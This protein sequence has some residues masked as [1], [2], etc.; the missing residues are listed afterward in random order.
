MRTYVRNS[1]AVIAMLIIVNAHV[2]PL[3]IRRNKTIESSKLNEFE[4]NYLQNET[5]NSIEVGK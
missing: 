2:E 3:E 4:T 1:A 5:E